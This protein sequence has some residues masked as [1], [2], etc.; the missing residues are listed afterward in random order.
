MSSY[1]RRSR[2]STLNTVV[3][4]LFII[5]VLLAAVT[6]VLLHLRST[7]EKDPDSVQARSPPLLRQKARRKPLP[8][9]RTGCPGT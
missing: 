8:P 1:N 2:H 3:L 4:I 5:A 9:I 7:L 6:L